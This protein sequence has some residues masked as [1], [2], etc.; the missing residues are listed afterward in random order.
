[1]LVV[2]LSTNTDQWSSVSS[3][4]F[5]LCKLFFF[6]H[7]TF[8]AVYHS[9]RIYT[10][11][12]IIIIICYRNL[13][14]AHE[15]ETELIF[16]L[17]LSSLGLSSSQSLLLSTVM[18]LSR[19]FPCSAIFLS[20]CFSSFNCFCP[21]LL[22]RSRSLHSSSSRKRWRF[23][24]SALISRSR[25]SKRFCGKC[26]S[27]HILIIGV[28]LEKWCLIQSHKAAVPQLPLTLCKSPSGLPCTHLPHVWFF[29]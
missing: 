28:L 14:K 27:I 19:S 7:Q 3:F 9:K 12:V 16:F 6:M 25:A 24:N 29:L 5:A 18:A 20:L 23:W 17:T 10:V 21:S 22:K 2:T 11:Y 26:T 1:M 15:H 4:Q 8:R 13:L